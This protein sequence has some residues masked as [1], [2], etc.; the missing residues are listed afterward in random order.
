MHTVDARSLR[1]RSW[2]VPLIAPVTNSEDKEILLK[3]HTIPNLQSTQHSSSHFTNLIT[4]AVMEFCYTISRWRAVSW[5]SRGGAH[6]W[7]HIGKS[8]EGLRYTVGNRCFVVVCLH[9]QYGLFLAGVLRRNNGPVHLLDRCRSGRGELFC[10]H[11]STTSPPPSHVVPS[12]PTII[13]RSVD[14]G[15][16][17]AGL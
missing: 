7:P 8:L 1:R 3:N 4:I 15:A 16:V 2:E 10:H 5:K 14:F 17:Q 12:L 11:G 13:Y 9:R 6:C